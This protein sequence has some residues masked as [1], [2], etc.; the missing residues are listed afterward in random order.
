MARAIVPAASERG[1][2]LSQPECVDSPVGRGVHGRVDG[3]AVLIGNARFLAERA[4]EVAVRS[5]RKAEALRHDGA[6]AIF[7]A[8]D[9]RAAGLIGIAD[10]VKAST[11]R[12][13]GGAEARGHPRRSC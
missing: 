6:T 3:R 12:G 10:P 13:A 1:L 5:M 4:V 8:V 11:P 7:V 2:R 9:G